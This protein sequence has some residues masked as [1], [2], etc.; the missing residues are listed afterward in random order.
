MKLNFP[1][2]IFILI[3]GFFNNTGGTFFNQSS[4]FDLITPLLDESKSGTATTGDPAIISYAVEVD[5][6]FATTYNLPDITVEQQISCYM[7]AINMHTSSVQQTDNLNTKAEL[8]LI[9][10]VSTPAASDDSPANQDTSNAMILMGHKTILALMA[11]LGFMT[12]Y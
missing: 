2:F 12:L 5:S 4:D 8:E 11:M 6:S 3:I 7:T 9:S 1:L 10:E